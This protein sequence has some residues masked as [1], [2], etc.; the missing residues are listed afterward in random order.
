MKQQRA[1]D[2]E[3]IKKRNYQRELNNTQKVDKIQ[4]A[5]PDQSHR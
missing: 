4:V 5:S 2:V 1:A 3:T